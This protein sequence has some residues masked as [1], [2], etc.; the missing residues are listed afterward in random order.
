LIKTLCQNHKVIVIEIQPSLHNNFEQ[1]GQ[2]QFP[3]LL[4]SDRF[5]R[6]TVLGPKLWL[7]PHISKHLAQTFESGVDRQAL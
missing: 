3:Q 6:I 2:V 5:V 1:F 7:E 4:I